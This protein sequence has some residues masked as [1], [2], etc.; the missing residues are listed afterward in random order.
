V[1]MPVFAEA[2]AEPSS[3]LVILHLVGGDNA[4][5]GVMSYVR[6]LTRQPLPGFEQFV[7]KHREYPP[8]NENTLPLGW[9]KTLDRRI[10]EDVIGAVLDVIPLYRWLRKRNPVII[11]AH[12]KM[13][14]FLSAF[15]RM[16]RPVPIV[17]HAHAQWRRTTIHRFLWR[18]THATVIFNSR[19]T[20]LHFGYPPET[21]HIHPPT[22]EWPAAPP[23]GNGRFVAAS[24]IQHWKNIHLIIEAFL[25]M[26]REGQSLHIYGF[27]PTA[28]E[29]GYQDEIVRMAKPHS[30]ICLHQWDPHWTDSLCRDDIFVHAA[31]REPFGIVML[32]AYARGCRMVVPCGTFLDELPSSGI[33]RSALNSP[34]LAQA[35]AA[36]FASPCS[37]DL[38][39]ERQAASH[40]FSLEETRQ[41]LS[42]IYHAKIQG[43]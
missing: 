29:S 37:S 15:I 14:T 9:S 21:S 28:L 42:E 34:A 31:L 25:R 17:I 26:A 30:N 5:G 13:G 43:R 40:L 22:I 10:F 24:N 19:A 27:S 39:R 20:C 38:W 36:A 41:K 3:K 6:A 2:K 16:I 35:M 4:N 32:E 11:N 1:T 7:W 8:E 23:T 18:L 33:F 12:T